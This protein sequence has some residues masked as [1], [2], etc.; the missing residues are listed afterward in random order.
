MQ[1]LRVLVVDDELGMRMGAERVLKECTVHVKDVDV[2]CDFDV[3]QADTGE[4]GLAKIRST[5]PD[6]LL[7]DHKL[8][9]IS[10]LEVLEDL[11]PAEKENLL[12]III[13]AYATIEHAVSAT[14]MGAYD[15]LAKPFTPAELRSTIKKATTRLILAREAKR[16]AEEKKQ[17]RFE[18]IRVLGHELKAPISAVEGYMNL[19]HAKTLGDDLEPYEQMVERSTM[20]LRQMRKLITDLLDMTRI[21]SGQMQRNLVELDVR[22]I[23]EDAIEAQK[24]EADKR[25]ITI[26]LNAPDA[27][28]FRGDQTELTMVFNNLVSN[29]VKYNRD[30]GRVSVAL[31]PEDHGI[32]ISV[33]DTGYGMTEDEVAKLFGEFV[34]IKNKNTR[35]VLGSGLGLSILKR[36]ANLYHG[37]VTV[38]SQPDI[39]TTFTVSL[40]SGNASE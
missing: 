32:S 23:A 33:A 4:D 5:P 22:T 27:L 26:S 36:I 6:I 25:D 17:V 19:L 35:N 11:T 39:G 34:R 28:P 7:L 38:A 3:D 40:Q 18:F 31:D 2:D 8:P 13:T 9:G 14:K 29:A 15:F 30:G 10:G 1:T 21:E 20:R 12:V 24:L 37:D 16:L